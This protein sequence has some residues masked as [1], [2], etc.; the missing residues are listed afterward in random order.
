MSRLAG[1]FEEF[2]DEAEELLAHLRRPAIVWL[3]SV[4]VLS[5]IPATL[6]TPSELLSG[7]YK[8]L[9]LWVVSRIIDYVVN[10][11]FVGA[12]PLKLFAGS[13]T[14]GIE[15]WFGSAMILA[16]VIALPVLVYDLWSFVA[17]GLTPSEQRTLSRYALPASMLFAAGSVYGLSVLTPVVLKV[18]Y[19]T[20]A[21]TGVEL[22]FPLK[23]LLGLIAMMSLFG[24]VLMTFPLLLH[25]L[26]RAG[27]VERDAVARNRKWIHLGLF[28]IVAFITPDG[29]LSNIVLYAPAALGLELILLINRNRKGS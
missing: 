20:A 13:L 16:T 25:A 10:G 27:I 8:P 29:S 5:V 9:S 28:T 3:V 11:S 14:I 18:L 23:D 21:W 6:I 4:F 22:L 12:V 24:G 26:I 17:V 1:L 15:L 7:F 2:K 19:I